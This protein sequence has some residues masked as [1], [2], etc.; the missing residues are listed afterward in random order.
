MQPGSPHRAHL[1]E[2]ISGGTEPRAD[3]PEISSGGQVMPVRRWW[4]EQ[5]PETCLELER[6]CAG[7]CQEWSDRLADCFPKELREQ[8][9]DETLKHLRLHVLPHPGPGLRQ[10]TD[11]FLDDELRNDILTGLPCVDP[12]P[13]RFPEFT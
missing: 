12:L 4:R 5:T 1:P 7:W 2:L 11:G 3:H 8:A 6:G 13:D 10:R 9:A